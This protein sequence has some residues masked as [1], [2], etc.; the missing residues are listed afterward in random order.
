[1]NKEDTVDYYI[2]NAWHAISRMYNQKAQAHGLSTSMAFVLL[3]IH[4]DFGTRAT[5]IAPL[6]GLESTSL[7]RML[8][9]MEETGLIE[10]RSDPTDGRAVRIFLTDEG[11]RKKEIAMETVM[12]FNQKVAKTVTEREFKSFVKV[13]EKINKV[14]ENINL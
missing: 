11:K 3:N 10:R 2:K 1:M 6:I 13:F 8:K 7:A 4:P 5:K 12:V 9:N 14:L